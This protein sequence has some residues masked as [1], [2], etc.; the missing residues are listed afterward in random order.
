MPLDSI[1]DQLMLS[2]Q[3]RS[4]MMELLFPQE[5]YQKKCSISISGFFLKSRE[6]Q[7]GIMMPRFKN[8]VNDNIIHIGKILN[9]RHV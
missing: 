8:S 1:I 4:Q 5:V 9:L 3:I 2:K 6:L 7:K